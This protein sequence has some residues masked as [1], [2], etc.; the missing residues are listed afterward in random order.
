MYVAALYID[1]ESDLF[2][3]NKIAFVIVIPNI[4]VKVYITIGRDHYLYIFSKPIDHCMVLFN[5]PNT[6]VSGCKQV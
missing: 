4:N 6:Q 1:C 3:S 5:N 2:S